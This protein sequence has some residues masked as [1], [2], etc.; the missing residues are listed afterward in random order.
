MVKILISTKIA[1]LSLL[2]I[3]VVWNKSY[4]AKI[5]VYDVNN[6]TLSRESN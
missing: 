3:K 4:D 1:T 5:S 2:Q 6:K